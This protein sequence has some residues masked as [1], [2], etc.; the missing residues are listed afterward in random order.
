[1]GSGDGCNH[2]VGECSAIVQ[3]WDTSGEPARLERGKLVPLGSCWVGRNLEPPHDAGWKA[4]DY[5]GRELGRKPK[6]EIDL[7]VPSISEIA[8]AIELGA[9]LLL[10]NQDAKNQEEGEG[11]L[12]G[13]FW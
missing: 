10:R 3:P 13:S 4:G 6:L 7:G 5:P 1:M 9:P 11:L 12:P 8:K 2:L